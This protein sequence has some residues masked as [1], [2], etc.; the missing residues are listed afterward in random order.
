MSG[1][2]LATHGRRSA[3][4]AARVAA[5]LAARQGISL[6]VV[7]VLERPPAIP[8]GFGMTSIPAPDELASMQ[9]M[10]LEKTAA[11]LGRCGVHHIAPA[12]RQGSLVSEILGAARAVGASL[13]VVG[14]G[15]HHVI[16]R[17]FG[18]ET[19]LHLAQIAPVPVLAV[20]GHATAIPHR[21]L[22]A[23]DFT[24]TSLL[25]AST[26]A[27]WVTGGD[28]LHVVHVEAQ[29]H[30]MRDAVPAAAVQHASRLDEA[31]ASL[32]TATCAD[33]DTVALHGDPARMLLDYAAHVEGDLIAIGSHGCGVWKRL[34]I[35]S[36]AWRIIRLT[37]RA[38]LVAPLAAVSTAAG[39]G[40][41]QRP[42]AT[43]DAA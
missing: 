26:V 18:G 8:D 32:Q 21:I 20:P 5:L 41:E 19:A 30:S 31:C 42:Y 1:I 25:A 27:Q 36:V 13:I 6:H 10:L 23:V 16:D 3:D 24:P 14:L 34:V 35:G 17:A 9:A 15:Q 33:V 40:L 2:L 22:A 37:S 12:C 11:Q 43:A 39:A 4:G 38:V 7:S 29:E 28:A